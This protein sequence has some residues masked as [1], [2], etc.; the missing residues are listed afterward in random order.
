LT[1]SPDNLKEAQV[2]PNSQLTKDQETFLCRLA[3]AFR[4]EIFDTVPASSLQ[5]PSEGY[6]LCDMA[7]ML[8]GISPE[9]ISG[10]LYLMGFISI[11]VAVFGGI[12]HLVYKITSK[13]YRAAVRILCNRA[14]SEG[15]T[16][17]SEDDVWQ[18]YDLWS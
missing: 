13:G 15:Y 8:A 7:R 1:D 5:A 14:I 2:M 17:S 12:G 9:C 18:L 3:D 4:N 16:L 11:Q 10:T 6:M